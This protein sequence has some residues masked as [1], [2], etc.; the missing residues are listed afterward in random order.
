MYKFN[1][2]M[3]YDEQ[4]CS[5]VS[6]TGDEPEI[7]IPEQFCGRQVTILLDNLFAGHP[8]LRSV[9]FPDSITDFG[10]FLFDGCDELRHI[11]LPPRLENLWGYTFVRCG[12]EQITLPDRVT[13]IPPYAFKDCKNL[14]KVVCGTGMKKIHSWAFGGCGQLTELVCGENVDVSTDAFK[15]ND[16]ILRLSYQ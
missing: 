6:Y 5:V 4:T 11:Q 1:Y 10:E 13:T 9:R 12:L 8:E 15:T 3:N 7:E 2:Q 16:R 14:R